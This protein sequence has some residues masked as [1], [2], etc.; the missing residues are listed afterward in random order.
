M[1][2]GYGYGLWLIPSDNNYN[3]ENI[4]SF[5]KLCNEKLF[6]NHVTLICNCTY[7]HA[8]LLYDTINENKTFDVKINKPLVKFN[9]EDYT[10]GSNNSCT[11]DAIGYN[12]NINE[13]DHITYKMDKIIRQY[14]ITGNVSYLP[15]MSLIYK[16]KIDYNY[17]DKIICKNDIAKKIIEN[18]DESCMQ[19][20]IVLADITAEEPDK[21]K[22]IC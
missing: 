15:H 22:I 8:K 10:Y 18:M 3:S 20:K 19:M 12:V 16:S 1:N 5:I 11:A 21:W 7:E 9:N 14:G 6:A 17:I 2:S 13:F 4:T